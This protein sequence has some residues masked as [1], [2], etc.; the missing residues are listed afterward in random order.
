M[1]RLLLEQVLPLVLVTAGIIYLKASGE[2]DYSLFPPR[3]PAYPA[4]SVAGTRYLPAIKGQWQMEDYLLSTGRDHEN[5]FMFGS[6]ELT[7]A[8]DANAY[9]FISKH[10]STQLV[11]VGEAGNQCFSIY[12]QLLACRERLPGAPVVIILSPGW[13]EGKY[14]AGTTAPVYMNYVSPW[15]LQKMMYDSSAHCR[16]Y[17]TKRFASLYPDITSPAPIHRDMYLLNCS[18]RDRFSAAYCSPLRVLNAFRFYDVPFTYLVPGKHA[19]QYQRQPFRTDTVSMNWDSLLQTART[20]AFAGITTNS[21]GINDDY[22]NQFVKGKTSKVHPVPRSSNTELDDFHELVKLLKDR[23]VNASFIIMPMHPHYYTNL[24]ELLPVMD[25]IT[26]TL[27]EA[28][29]PVYN[30][31][32][33]DTAAYD[34]ALLTDVMHPGDYGWYKMSRFIVETYQLRK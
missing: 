8:S 9:R 24:H 28:K 7:S 4:A 33:T 10:F 30:M 16:R 34:K 21:I 27:A 6:S 32:V 1:K 20:N 19:L 25:E 5:I 23:N 17:V 18:N 12:S 11:A 15:M 26:T 2:L 13:F 31:F 29:L 14:A 22:Y 3:A